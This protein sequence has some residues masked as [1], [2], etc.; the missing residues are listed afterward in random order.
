M[1]TPKPKLEESLKSARLIH[2]VATGLCLTLLAFALSSPYWT[3]RAMRE[4]RAMSLIDYDGFREYAKGAAR[5]GYRRSTFADEV[6]RELERGGVADPAFRQ[7]LAKALRDLLG[8]LAERPRFLAPTPEKDATVK[9]VYAYFSRN[10]HVEISLPDQ[11]HLVSQI[12]YWMGKFY[13]KEHEA[14]SDIRFI[15]DKYDT[16]G[17]YLPEGFK[18]FKIM[19]RTGG[20]GLDGVIPSRS[21]PLEGWPF[22]DWFRTRAEAKVLL[23]TEGRETT[24]FPAVTSNAWEVVSGKRPADAVQALEEYTSK[25]G[26]LTFL[27]LSVPVKLASFAGPSATLILLLYQLAHLGHLRK[28]CERNPA[29][30]REFPWVVTIG[31]RLSGVL[32]FLSVTALPVA[33]NLVLLNRTWDL[34][35]PWEHGTAIACS[36]GVAVVGV[37]ILLEFLELAR[38]VRTPETGL[39]LPGDDAF[40]ED[41]VGGLNGALTGAGPGASANPPDGGGRLR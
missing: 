35:S 17:E 22:H 14:W 12:K 5:E 39:V 23:A 20:S 40:P 34:S 13:S 36:V 10:P 33:A 19:V 29:E 21:V 25:E 2:Q 11:A 31:N 4:L 38:I 8:R 28:L 6:T 3:D 1:A 7:L 18:D 41:W 16:Y 15:L 30:A 32:S 26:R 24:V 37:L 27:G 9:D